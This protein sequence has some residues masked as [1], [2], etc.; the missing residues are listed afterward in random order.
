MD[1]VNWVLI[2][3]YD[4]VVAVWGAV[5]VVFVAVFHA[6]DVILEPIF[7]PLLALLN[8]ICTALGDGIYAV[9]GPLPPWLSLTILSAIAGLL[10]LVV[11]RYTSNQKAIGR[12]LDDIK[13]NLLALKLYKDE[14]RVTFQAQGRLLWAI[15]RLQRYMLTPFLVMLT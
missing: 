5:K 1:A 3:G 14:L 10:A 12:A 15:A 6:L 7:S 9:L 13:A 11:F 4:A 8:P 2:H